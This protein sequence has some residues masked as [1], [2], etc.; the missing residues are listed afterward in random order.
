[1]LRFNQKSIARKYTLNELV[2]ISEEKDLG[3]IIKNKLNLE[4]HIGEKGMKTNM[5]LGVKQRSFNHFDFRN[6]ISFVRPHLDSASP[7]WSSYL[8]KRV[9]L[10]EKVQRR[11][12][13]EGFKTLPYT[14]KLRR[15]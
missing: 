4:D 8:K 13:N 3:V 9:N 6:D 14:E 12:K 7:V 10:I 15:L 5:I 11:A 2:N 1:M